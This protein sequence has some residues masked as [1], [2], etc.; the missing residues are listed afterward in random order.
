MLP[1]SLVANPSD[2]ALSFYRGCTELTFALPEP[3]PAG[4]LI[5]DLD[6]LDWKTVIG[7]QTDDLDLA[8]ANSLP[9]VCLMTPVD[10]P[11]FTVFEEQQDLTK[12][13]FDASLEQLIREYQ[14]I[15][16]PTAMNISNLTPVAL[17]LK[18]KFRDRV[19]HRAEYRKSPKVQY[20]CD[21]DGRKILA[22]GYGRLNPHSPH[23]IN[24]VRVPRLDKDG[25]P[26]PVERDRWCLDLSFVNFALEDF[27][28]PVPR[29]DEIL[30]KMAES[31]VFSELDV[32]EAFNSMRINEELSDLY[33]R[34]QRPSVK[35]LT[36]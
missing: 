17:G 22:S 34:S 29:I 10:A 32:K 24:R 12:A 27:D 31:K 25:K 9:A 35:F 19:F 4:A 26:L 23:N 7:D 8:A 13:Q 15:F 36:W 16:S 28:H 30:E 5:E 18:P 14:D 2:D 6:W 21:L 11:V 3:D 33:S 20:S 1:T